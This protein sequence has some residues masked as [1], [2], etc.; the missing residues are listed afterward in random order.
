MIESH[1]LSSLRR[2]QAQGHSIHG[3]TII[4]AVSG[5]ADS[6][7]LLFILLSLREKLKFTLRAVHVEHGIRGAES[8]A[9]Q[10][11]VEE[12]CAKLDVPLDVYTVDA[13]SFAMQTQEKKGI[14][15]AARTLRYG[16]FEKALEKNA[17]DYVALAH[18]KG[19]QSETLML[20]IIHGAG[21]AGLC[22]MQE[23]RDR[24]IRPLLHVTHEEMK[25]YLNQIDQK[26][27]ED[28]T[29]RDEAQVR[30]F[31]RMN[32]L[33][34]MRCVNPSVDEA[35]AR[36]AVIAS[37]DDSYLSQIT[38][39][40]IEKNLTE[41]PF[42]YAVNIEETLHEAI[43]SRVIVCAIEKVSGFYLGKK[44]ND[45]IISIIHDGDSGKTEVSKACNVEWKKPNLYIIVNNSAKVLDVRVNNNDNFDMAQSN[46]K[47]AQIVPKAL[48]AK[49]EWRFRQNGDWIQ[50]FG[51]KGTVSLSDYLIDK[52]T[53]RPTRD[54]IPLLALGNEVLWAVGVGASEK[55][56]FSARD[57]RREFTL[58]TWRGND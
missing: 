7:A 28:V 52:K 58:L 53:A 24:F 55:L 21:I 12:L 39:G 37:R 38:N 3:K 33:P 50:P 27:C 35:L 48:I 18:H 41:A 4:A 13:P 57:E 44:K 15:D 43:L 45:E 26:W 17:G 8:V 34:A 2:I 56:R 19:D 29:N 51:V 54:Y 42:G 47:T 22:G 1:V 6:V 16:A 10:R 20:H 25:D 23:V 49:A 31:L 11:F 30:A 14:E 40:Y 5:G 32:V 36:L 9:D 46:G